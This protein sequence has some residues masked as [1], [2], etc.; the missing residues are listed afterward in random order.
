VLI[1]GQKLGL[2]G[3]GNMSQAIIGGVVSSKTLLPEEIIVSNPSEPKLKEAQDK[4][5]IETTTH[6]IEVT[7]VA[8][9]IILAVKPN[10]YPEVISEIKDHIRKNTII[11][12]IAAGISIDRTESLFEKEVKVARAMPNTPALV[13]EAMTHFVLTKYK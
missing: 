8:D 9:I 1:N 13:K 10:K 4:Y 11:A 5:K 6:N 3:C 12:T 7:K 2:I